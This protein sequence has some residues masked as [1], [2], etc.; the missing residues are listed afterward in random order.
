MH[1]EEYANLI[2][3]LPETALRQATVSREG[4]ALLVIDMQHY[5]GSVVDEIIPN[6]KRVI[7]ACRNARIPIVYTQHGYDDPLHDSGMLGEWWDD[8]IIEGTH[9]WEIIDEIAPRDEEKVIRKTRYSAFYGTDLEMHLKNRAIKNV[10]IGGVV[11]NLCCE[12][13]ARDAFVRDFRV[14][15]LMDGTATVSKTYH[16]ASLRNLAY[17]FAYLKRCE[18]IVDA[19]SSDTPD[20]P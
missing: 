6:M 4:T 9:K 17:G 16:V 14:F 11:T 3:T 19:F 20:V 10:I 13:T 15:F 1:S 7:E 8:P 5:F 2:E 18:E 12:T